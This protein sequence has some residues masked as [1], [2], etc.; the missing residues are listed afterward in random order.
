MSRNIRKVY[1]RRMILEEASRGLLEYFGEFIDDWTSVIEPIGNVHL[2]VGRL[3]SIDNE[4]M[5]RYPTC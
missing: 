1:T 4:N 2:D 3:Y 5:E